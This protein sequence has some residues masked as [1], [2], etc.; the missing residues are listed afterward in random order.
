MRNQQSRELLLLKNTQ[1]YASMN[2][3]EQ[4]ETIRKFKS[5]QKTERK[6]SYNEFNDTG[7]QNI[8][9]KTTR[10]YASKHEMTRHYEIQRKRKLQFRRNNNLPIAQF[11]RTQE[12]S[13]SRRKRNR[14]DEQQESHEKRMSQDMERALDLEQ[15]QEDRQ[16]LEMRQALET[17]TR[18]YEWIRHREF[19][20]EPITRISIN[21]Q[22]AQVHETYTREQWRAWD[23]YDE[24]Q[25]EIERHG[26]F[27]NPEF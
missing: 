2:T 3:D 23:N 24:R 27:E 22:D 5:T 9:S 7:W 6:R 16:R 25:E 21:E 11:N 26:V 8:L 13:A 4:R 10:P 19:E 18:R 14:Q 20:N 17:N 1:R 12:N 15:Q